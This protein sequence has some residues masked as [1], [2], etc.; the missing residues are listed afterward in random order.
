M[1]HKQE[2]SEPGKTGSGVCRRWIQESRWAGE[3][4][5]ES[6][7][8]EASS[9]FREAG[10]SSGEA[11]LPAASCDIY[12][13]TLNPWVPPLRLSTP[14][15]P[16]IPH[17]SLC[18]GFVLWRRFLKHSHLPQVSLFFA[19]SCWG[20]GYAAGKSRWLTG[21]MLCAFEQCPWDLYPPHKCWR[22]QRCSWAAFQASLPTTPVPELVTVQFIHLWNNVMSGYCWKPVSSLVTTKEL[23]PKAH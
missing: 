11:G 23:A 18:L 10:S 7:S 20:R 6:Q 4:G 3:I 19:E 5:R 15:T 2:E 8:R 16:L 13:P 17:V 21:E 22:R 9:V 14:R 1:S 12:F